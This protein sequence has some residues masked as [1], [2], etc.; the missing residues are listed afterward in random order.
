M[1]C[2][3]CHSYLHTTIET[4][5]KRKHYTLVELD[6]IPTPLA[7]MCIQCEVAYVGRDKKETRV[8]YKRGKSRN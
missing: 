2:L 5:A 7:F 1:L 6:N 4:A 3:N 8:S